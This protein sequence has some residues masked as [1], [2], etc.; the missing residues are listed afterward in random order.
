MAKKKAAGSLKNGRDSISRRLGIKK[1]SGQLV[2]P[3]NI[4]VRQK[5]SKF[6]PGE[7]TKMGKD[8]T[9]YSVSSGKI[10][11]YKKKSKMIIKVNES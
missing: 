6:F 8:Y 5:G 9:I 11:F 3:G 1:Y 4:I 7:N 2:K 10:Y